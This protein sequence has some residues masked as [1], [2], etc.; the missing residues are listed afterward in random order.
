MIRQA[1]RPQ[2]KTA[3]STSSYIHL[4]YFPRACGD[5]APFPATGFHR[6]QGDQTSKPVI[7]FF[8]Y[9]F[10]TTVLSQWDFSHGKFRLPSPGK[11]SWDTV[12]LPNLGCMRLPMGMCRHHKRVSTE[13]GLWEK[14]PLP[15]E[16]IKPALAACRSNAPLPTELHPHSMTS[17]EVI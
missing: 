14:N 12:M 16:A 10:F 15:H 6:K 13:S 11:A 3:L 9:N 7:F 17:I 8:F 4:C 5:A 2:V 1:I